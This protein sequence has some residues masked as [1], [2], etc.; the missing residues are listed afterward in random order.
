LA[1]MY[2]WDALKLSLPI[3]V[4]KKMLYFYGN[5][6]QCANIKILTLGPDTRQN[7]KCTQK[8]CNRPG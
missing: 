6:D 3:K 5:A 8:N 2:K 4:V 7:R 1:E